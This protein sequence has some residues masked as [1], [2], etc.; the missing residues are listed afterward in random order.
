MDRTDLE[1]WKPKEV[2]RLLSLV[3]SE[4]RYYQEMVVL[5]PV[6]LAVVSPDAFV[7]VGEPRVPPVV[8]GPRR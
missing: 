8:W 7:R 3:E 2:A 5:L 4:R 1:Q 6:P